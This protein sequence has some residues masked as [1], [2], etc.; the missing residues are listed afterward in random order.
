VFG[1]GPVADAASTATALRGFVHF[2]ALMLSLER[3]GITEPATFA[4]AARRA[5]QLDALESADLRRASITAYQSVIGLVR[6]AHDSRILTRSTAESLAVTLSG[7]DASADGRYIARL[8]EWMRTD[9]LPALPVAAQDAAAP[10]ENA[11]L[12]AIAGVELAA[13]NEATVT[14][15][16]AHYRGDREGARLLRL[17][18][19][20]SRQGGLSLDVALAAM[21]TDGEAARSHRGLL[22][23]PQRALAE[24]LESILYA[25]YLSDPEGPG[26]APGNP[27]LRHDLGRSS[28]TGPWRSHSAWEPPVEDFAAKGGWRVRGALLGLDLAFAAK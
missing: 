20:R 10:A 18:S 24:T 4:A 12:S 5:A 28:P 19:I 6:R 13:E 7:L 27:A 15:P 2:P 23:A 16:D 1:E 25:A 8:A 11:V 21:A 9:L 17:R 3:M 14:W 26:V 22:T